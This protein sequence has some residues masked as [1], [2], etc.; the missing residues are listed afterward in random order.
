MIG[1]LSRRMVYPLLGVTILLFLMTL[2]SAC[3]GQ[4][5]TEESEPTDDAESVGFEELLRAIPDTPEAR[6]EVYI[7]DYTLARR[8]FD[9]SLPG[10]GDDEAALQ[11]FYDWSPP[12][13]GK[14]YGDTIPVLGFGG[15]AFFSPY[16]H[17]R[18]GVTAHIQYLAYLAFDI[19]SMDQTILAG[20]P[21]NKLDVTLGRFDPKATDEALRSCSECPTPDR[22]EYGGVSYYSWGRD[23]KVDRNMILAPP[24]FDYLGRGGRIAVL[25][26]YVFHT[27]ATDEMKSLIGALRDEVP[28]LADLEEYRLLAATMSQLGA[29]SML[30]SDDT[31]GL[32]SMVEGYLEGPDATNEEAAKLREVLEGPGTLRPYQAFATG[33]GKDEDGPYMALALVH[34]NSGPAEEN[35]E[36]LRRRIEEGSSSVYQTPWLDL[37]DVATLEIHSEERLLLAKLRGQISTVSMDWVGRGDNLIVHD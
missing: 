6:R 3:G 2:L 33:A 27:W 10:P 18:R 26:S 13:D 4:T 22:E 21:D 35:V 36:L 11:E 20:P 17:G 32:D 24:A 16:Y 31:F 25:D 29:Y 23:N 8:L 1:L 14:G 28:S 12:Y 5:A 9:I 37:I 19:R 30:L 7:D 34:A 15:F